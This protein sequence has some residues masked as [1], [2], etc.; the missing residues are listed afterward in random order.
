MAEPTLTGRCLCGGV[1]FEAIGEPVWVAW[2][3]CGS[4]R[5]AAGTPVTAYAGY[6]AAMVRFTAG[7]PTLFASSPGVE[8]GFCARCGSSISF[9]GERWPGEIHLHLGCFEDV[10]DLVPTDEAYA[11]ERL[12]WVHLALA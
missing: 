5:R 4:C 1:R 12:P 6:P 8:R 11:E 2:C 3:H 7:S 9:V 10:A